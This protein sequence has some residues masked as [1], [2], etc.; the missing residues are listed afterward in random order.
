[1]RGYDVICDRSVLFATDPDM[2]LAYAGRDVVRFCIPPYKSGRWKTTRG[3]AFCYFVGPAES[4]GNISMIGAPN[5]FSG[6]SENEIA[7][8][9]LAR[10]C[11]RYCPDAFSFC[12]KMRLAM[13]MHFHFARKCAWRP[14]VV[15]ARSSFSENAIGA[16]AHFH[17][18][19]E[20][21]FWRADRI[22]ILV[23]KCKSP[24]CCETHLV[25]LVAFSP[26]AKCIWYPVRIVI[27]GVEMHSIPPTAFHFWRMP[28][29][30]QL[31]VY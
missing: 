22:S 31:F 21:H 14:Q 20:M 24:F 5:A 28:L 3:I 18:G 25:P 9:Q 17:F 15:Y 19:S 11:I 30:P 10:K 1:M 6:R 7:H 26:G 23:R 4:P 8:F 2:A 13:Q 27:F 16:Q 12:A 29:A